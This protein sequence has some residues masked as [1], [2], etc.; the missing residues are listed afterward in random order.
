MKKLIYVLIVLALLA[1]ASCLNDPLHVHPELM[2]G[3]AALMVFILRPK[4]AKTANGPEK[5]DEMPDESA[6]E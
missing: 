6:A 4:K 2:L 1:G 5:S 3:V